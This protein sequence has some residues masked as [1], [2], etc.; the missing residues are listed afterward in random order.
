MGPG[1]KVGAKPLFNEVT[2][3]IRKLPILAF[4]GLAAC[5]VP[6]YRGVPVFVPPP[7]PEPPTAVIPLSAKERFLR[8]AAENGC[9]VNA[10]TSSAIMA[11][12][13]LSKDDL[14]RVVQ[15]LRNEGGAEVIPGRGI[16]VTAGACA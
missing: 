5:A 8:A 6:D 2:V 11:S 3:M 15:D 10:Q 9:E 14:G 16:A 4:V 1:R 12:A 13:T 7:E